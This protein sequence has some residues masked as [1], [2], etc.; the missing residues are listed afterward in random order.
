MS[1]VVPLGSRDVQN[2]LQTLEATVLQ[3]EILDRLRLLATIYKIKC[4]HIKEFIREQK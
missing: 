4:K 2:N 1:L 3:S